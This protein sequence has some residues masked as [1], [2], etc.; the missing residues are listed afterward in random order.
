MA[1]MN[2]VLPIVLL[3]FIGYILKRINFISDGF[4]SGANK[5]VF[6]FAIPVMLFMNVYNVQNLN[7]VNWNIV[8]YA[9]AG[10]LSLFGL[11][12]L[13]VFLFTK[14]PLK[15]G[16]VLQCI[17][18]PNFAIIGIPL[19]ALLT[20]NSP[21]ALMVTSVLTLFIIPLT[22]ILAVVSLSIYPKGIDNE[23][24]VIQQKINWGYTFQKIATNPLIIGILTGF[25]VV[26]IRPI[27]QGFTIRN[28]VPFIFTTLQWI[29]NIA[30]P[31]AL[32]ALGAAFKFGAFRR[33][34]PQIIHGTLWRVIIA[35]TMLIGIAIIFRNQLG[36][37]EYVFPAFIALF[38]APVAVTSVVMAEEMGNDGEL[39]GQLVVWNSIVSIFTVFIIVMILMSMGLVAA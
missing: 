39:A 3:I 1:A 18:R 36:F 4:L 16:V 21:E 22:N 7:N 14:D 12:L 8:W 19:V 34:L 37:D 17:V 11:G 2:A 15:K 38:A 9:V 6:R 32:I 35:P 33:L 20:G 13:S 28:D 5:L 30:S 27:F 26:L 25:I 10:V 31:L 29:Q 23:G 24:N